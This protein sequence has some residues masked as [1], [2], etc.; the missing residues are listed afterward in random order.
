MTSTTK[1]PVATPAATIYPSCWPI[2]P[3]IERA[4]I[5]A[6]AMPSWKN[7]ARGARPARIDP[8]LRP[9][10]DSPPK[11]NPVEPT[12]TIG[13]RAMGTGRSVCSSWRQPPVKSPVVVS[14]TTHRLLV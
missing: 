8:S 1:F 10:S 2:S 5:V 14:G 13:A 9:A 7:G 4:G 11:M 12:P 3:L 6:P